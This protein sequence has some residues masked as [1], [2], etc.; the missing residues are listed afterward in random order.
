MP[1]L[2]ALFA[3]GTAS[4]Q[5]HEKNANIGSGPQQH[6][7]KVLQEITPEGLSVYRQRIGTNRGNAYPQPGAFATLASGLSVFSSAS[8][9][10]SAPSPSG[11]ESGTITEEIIEQ[12]IGLQPGSR[13]KGAP[14]ENHAAYPPVAN[15]PEKPG[16]VVPA[17]A[18][19]QQGP[20]T[21]NGETSQFRTR[22]RRSRPRSNRPREAR[23]TASCLIEHRRAHRVL[24]TKMLLP[25]VKVIPTSVHLY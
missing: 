9:A 13:K 16:N 25:E 2:Q 7:L 17:P 20:F 1:D 6:F 11:P 24:W 18:C 12:L 10:D 23:S 8:C 4:T 19:K 22:R 21:F 5:T 14:V 3:N 15:N